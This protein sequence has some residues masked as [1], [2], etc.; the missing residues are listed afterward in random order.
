MAGSHGPAG[1]LRQLARSP[2]QS[3]RHLRGRCLAAVRRAR[4]RRGV[5]PISAG[6][7]PRPA[8]APARGP[9][10]LEVALTRWALPL[11]ALAAVVYLAGYTPFVL[12]WP[13]VSSDEGREMNA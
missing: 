4:G 5:T 8:T 2:L 7:P 10:G 1:C 6:S 3:Q 11:V 13:P 9:G 12:T